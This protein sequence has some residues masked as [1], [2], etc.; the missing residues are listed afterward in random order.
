MKTGIC[1]VIGAGENHGL[2]FVRTGDDYVIAVDGGLRY[3]DEAGIAPDLVIGDFDSLDT[4]PQGPNVIRLNPVKD[5]TDMLAALKEGMGRGFSRFHLYCGM[6][7]RIEHT[8]ANIQ[9][10]AYLSQKGMRGFLHDADCFLTTLTDE[11]LPLPE[12]EVGYLSVF[13]YTEKCEGVFLRGLK[14]EL[15]NATL[16]S[17][18]PLGISNEFQGEKSSIS[19]R[20][21]TLLIVLPKDILHQLPA[22]F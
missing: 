22:V 8:I 10:L 4:C 18:F 14:Y 15:D 7:G 2:D 20:S 6:G 1:Y 9:L 12:K 11:T 5:D 21:G 17:T 16:R 13:S 19:V 3:L